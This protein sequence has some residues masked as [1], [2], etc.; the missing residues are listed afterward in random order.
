M[1]KRFLARVGTVMNCRDLLRLLAAVAVVLGIAANVHTGN[2]EP[3]HDCVT[4]VGL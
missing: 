1:I 2:R 4:D 3:F